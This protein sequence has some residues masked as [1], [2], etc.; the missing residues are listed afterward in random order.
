[1]DPISTSTRLE[2]TSGSGKLISKN[3]VLMVACLCYVLLLLAWTFRDLFHFYLFALQSRIKRRSRGRQKP[4]FDSEARQRH[5]KT[6]SI[7]C[8]TVTY[9]KEEIC[10]ILCAPRVNEDV[11]H[12]KKEKN[13]KSSIDSK[14]MRGTHSFF[15]RW[16]MWLLFGKI[17]RW[18]ISLQRFLAPTH[19]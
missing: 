4:I 2:P 6:R 1:M 11:A 19:K 12:Y 5:S 15:S 9:G 18:S 8:S 10:K 13:R 16:Q 14:E 3:T 17:K 7:G